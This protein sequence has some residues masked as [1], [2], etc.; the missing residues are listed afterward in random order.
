LA[1]YARADPA[2]EVDDSIEAV[3][4]DRR[5]QEDERQCCSDR[6]GARRAPAGDACQSASGTLTG[7]GTHT[8]YR[9]KGE[10]PAEHFAIDENEEIFV[11]QST[12]DKDGQN[13]KDGFSATTTD[14]LKDTPL[15][16]SVNPYVISAPEVED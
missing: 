6:K 4:E 11:K 3:D 7:D 12:G 14:R 9:E 8:V 16:P 1:E 13:A 15:E 2:V 10:L 5:G